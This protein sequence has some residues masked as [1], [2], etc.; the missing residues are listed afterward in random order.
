MRLF[1]I[2]HWFAGD[3][4][5]ATDFYG[6]FKEEL[7]GRETVKAPNLEELFVWLELSTLL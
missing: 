6:I 1:V 5:A 2:A 3:G 7:L 4:A